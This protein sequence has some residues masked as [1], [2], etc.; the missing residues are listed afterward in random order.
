MRKIAQRIFESLLFKYDLELSPVLPA[1]V[2][3]DIPGRGPRE[4]KTR[5]EAAISI[6]ILANQSQLNLA[7]WRQTNCGGMLKVRAMR[8]L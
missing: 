7:S 2:L 6:A 8:F 5:L 1:T 3:N 4:L